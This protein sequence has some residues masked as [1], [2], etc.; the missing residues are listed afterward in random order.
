M[1][2]EMASTQGSYYKN[3]LYELKL[4]RPIHS[5]TSAGALVKFGNG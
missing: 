2:M 5:L 3:E 4:L 1:N